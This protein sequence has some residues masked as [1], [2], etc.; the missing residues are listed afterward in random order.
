MTGEWP[1]DQID[2]KNRVGTDNRWENLRAATNQQNQF[3]TT[4][5]RNNKC[6]LKGVH[7]SKE[8]KKWRAQIG[9][10]G[11]TWSL[12]YYLTPEDASAAYRDAASVHARV[13]YT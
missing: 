3:N 7:W 4:V 9:L 5:R 13:G 6:G 10:N 1:A 8:K 2:H 11:K 12:G